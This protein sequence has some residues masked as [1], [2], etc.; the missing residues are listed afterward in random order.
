[1]STSIEQA[2]DLNGIGQSQECDTPLISMPSWN[3]VKQ[4]RDPVYGYIQVPTPYVSYLIG[5]TYMQRIKGVAQSGLRPLFA[6]A[7]HDRFAHSV[8]VYR[9]AMLLYESLRKS[10]KDV[11]RKQGQYSGAWKSK[12]KEWK[13]LLA[14]AALL[15]DI[16][17]PIQSHSMEFLYDDVFLDFSKTAANMGDSYIQTF[18]E[19]ERERVEEKYQAARQQKISYEKSPFKIA[20]A[21]EKRK[22]NDALKTVPTGG[23]QIAAMDKNYDGSP[24]ERMSAYY[25]LTDPGLKSNIKQLC[26]FYAKDNK[27]GRDCNDAITHLDELD[28]ICRMITGT[29]YQV[30][31]NLKNNDADLEYSLRNCVIHI[32]NGTIDADS[33]D[34]IMRNSYSS[35]YSTSEVDYYRFCG[36][37]SVYHEQGQLFL[38]WKKGALSV[39]EGFISARN[40]EPRWLYSHH[41]VVY[42]DVLVKEMLIDAVQ[43][44]AMHQ[45]KPAEA[46]SAP[47]GGAPP[48]DASTKQPAAWIHYPFFTYILAPFVPFFTGKYLFYQSVDGDIESF[49]KQIALEM[50]QR[51][52]K[53]VPREEKTLIDEYLLLYEEHSTRQHK[54]S[55]WKSFSE[56]KQALTQIACRLDTSFDTINRFTLELIQDGLLSKQFHLV[57]ADEGMPSRHYESEIIYYPDSTHAQKI[58]SNTS[59]GAIHGLI[60]RHIP[61]IFG[62]FNPALCRV[63]IVSPREKDFSKEQVLLENRHYNLSEMLDLEKHQLPC[64]PYLYYMLSNGDSIEDLRDGFFK[65]LE[66]YCRQ[67]IT[68]SPVGGDMLFSK[69]SGAVV[70]DVVHGDIPLPEPYLAV[71]DT[72]EFQ[73]LRRI[74]QLSTAIQVFPNAGHSRFSHSLG[75]YYVMTKIVDHFEN[76]CAAQ[77]MKL[78]HNAQER[79]V[80]LLSAL[81][82]DLGHGPYSHTFEHITGSK[83]HEEW[84]GDI[85][86]D[87]DTCINQVIRK[88]FG[89][90]MPER[91]VECIN[92]KTSS[93]DVFSFADIYPT[94][95]SSQLDADRLDYLVRDSYN[96]AIQF[97]NVDIQNLISAMRITVIGQKYSVAIEE[98]HLSMVEH[99]LFGRF[100]MYEMVYYNAYK[101]FSEELFQRICKRVKQLMDAEPY[102][103]W[104]E[105]MRHSA[106]GEA[107]YCVLKGNE[108]KTDQYLLLDDI[109]VEARFSQWLKLGDKILSL[110]VQAFLDRNHTSIQENGAMGSIFRRIRV[111]HE[112]DEEV[113]DLLRQIEALLRRE[114]VDFLK[115]GQELKDVSYAFINTMRRCTMYRDCTALQ[116]QADNQNVIWLL[117]ENGTVEDIGQ[118]SRMLGDSFHKSYLYYCEDIFRGELQEKSLP[119]DQ[120]DIILKGVS[121]LMA[122]SHPRKM[123]EIEEKYS[124][125]EQTL[126]DV[127]AILQEYALDN[128]KSHEGFYLDGPSSDKL[129]KV[130]EQEDTYFDLPSNELHRA[131]CSFRCRCATEEASGKRKKY[132]FTIKRPTDSKNFGGNEQFAR[133]EFEMEAKS[134]D[135]NKDVIQFVRSHLDLPALLGRPALSDDEISELLRPILTIS[136]RRSKGTVRRCTD[137]QGNSPFEAEICLDDVTYRRSS[138]SEGILG[139]RDWQIELELKSEYLDRVLLKKFT[140]QLRS[141]ANLISHLTPESASK[142]KKA[143]QLLGMED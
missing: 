26:R 18:D 80:V 25:I 99:F 122:A 129:L 121:E 143:R 28:F 15:H 136:N 124:C 48:Q 16:G 39:I 91:I 6:A 2:S 92:H 11:L 54:K 62:R 90:D 55:L 38:A 107:L 132:I 101:L 20:M 37:L 34:Y 19:Q 41:K 1:M 120:I 76:L 9:F 93:Q 98:G 89:T 71:V 142:Y 50:R 27:I 135:L 4:F 88:K 36:A 21:E 125:G 106:A 110:L 119:S 115:L 31:N 63:K 103:G 134:P 72:P 94:L 3:D 56:Y 29:R 33:M 23:H 57:Q 105:E 67:R 52:Q 74:K 141:H 44:M 85:I 130:V 46:A 112:K 10:A 68:A 104:I 43:Y 78:F 108:L 140:N 95:V 113:Q 49:F 45:P 30:P 14:I 83:S 53:G 84:T 118:V 61:K 138:D 111:F 51:R 5:T 32:L 75:T 117:R 87:S 22:I 79:D 40:Y 64:F 24:H 81:L 102:A 109:A 123:I 13:N 100:K 66:V 128:W 96:T 47:G 126:L 65:A 17:H 131:S 133:F 82:H 42:Q 114:G 116:D 60:C 12:L 97:G 8:G 73:R 69:N 77:G 127:K 70:R 7:T 86:R 137:S 58:L 59:A 35:G 139:Q